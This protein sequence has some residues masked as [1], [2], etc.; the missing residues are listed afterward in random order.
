[1]PLTLDYLPQVAHH[2]VFSAS[3]E[4]SLQIRGNRF[5]ATTVHLGE[6]A[7]GAMRYPLRQR[8]T[9]QY[10]PASGELII[11]G[12]G[13]GFTGRG[14]TLN[15]AVDDFRLTVHQR[16]QELMNRRPFEM[17]AQ[18]AADW[19]TLGR[20]IDETAFRN[21]LPIQMRQFGEV[22]FMKRSRPVCDPLGQRRG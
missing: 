9:G 5:D 20:M 11:E 13:S 4:E 16:F 12:F 6:L 10:N 7:F 8:L 2:A 1:M 22:Q 3:S 19:A 17:D 21:S 15:E 14:D 18:D